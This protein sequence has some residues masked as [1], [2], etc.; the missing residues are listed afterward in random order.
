MAGGYSYN[1][2]PANSDPAAIGVDRDFHAGNGVRFPGGVKDGDVAVVLR[3]VANRFF[4]SVEDPL[5]DPDT[6]APGY[7]CWGF[8]YRANA[9]NPNN[10]SN[11]SSG[12]ALDISAPSHP[13]GASGTFTDGQVDA[14]R[15]ILA[16]CS[17]TVYWGGDY[18]GTSDEMH[19]EICRGPA[20]VAA[21]AARLGDV[22]PPEPT[23]APEP[24]KSYYEQLYG[25]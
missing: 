24:P 19:F 18:S 3:H 22:A 21:A 6:G 15:Q 7:G 13:N 23:P 9:N 4:A 12:T 16:E 5:M 20:D 8:N 1:G 25:L 2:W 10:L 17:Y 14:I 11:H